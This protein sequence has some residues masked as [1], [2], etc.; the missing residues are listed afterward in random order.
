MRRRW[1]A[2]L[3]VLAVAWV[4]AAADLPSPDTFG[5]IA[6]E[7]ER[8]VALFEAA[9]EVLQHPRCVNCHPR[10]DQPLQNDDMALHQ[11]PVERGIG[12][13]GAFGMQCI[14][15]H[16]QENYDPAGVPGHPKWHL[17]PAE[18]AWEGA[19]LGQ[20]CAQLKDPA[21]NGGRDLAAIVDHAAN[22]SLVGWGWAPGAK[23]EPAP[24][25]QAQFG[26]LMAAW[27]ETGAHCPEP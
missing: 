18:M 4:A 13:M 5:D 11:P 23:L 27:V 8:S 3:P 12:G 7:A 21:R 20:I 6:D 10:G 19:D 25:T 16:G 17:A 1:A 9:G 26:A 2:G 15:C 22:D 24:G 14:V